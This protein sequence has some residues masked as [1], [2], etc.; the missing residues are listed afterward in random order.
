M[1]G[2]KGRLAYSIYLP[3]QKRNQDIFDGSKRYWTRGLP[4]SQVRKRRAVN[5]LYSWM[6]V[7][8]RMPDDSAAT[9]KSG[10]ALGMWVLAFACLSN[11]ASEGADAIQPPPAAAATPDPTRIYA[12]K[13]KSHVE[14]LGNCQTSELAPAVPIL[15]VAQK[16][17]G[18]AGEQ[19]R[20]ARTEFL[21]RMGGQGSVDEGRCSPRPP[22]PTTAQHA[23]P[24]TCANRRRHCGRP[25]VDDQR[26]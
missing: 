25:P 18:M 13:H 7:K 4:N 5:L 6:R 23:D 24:R 12:A 3:S 11:R 1:V 2:T 14:H 22:C 21:S 9:S 20:L 26:R 19:A 15:G 17:G 10:D 8:D 16:A